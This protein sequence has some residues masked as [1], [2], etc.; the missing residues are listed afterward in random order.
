MTKEDP[1]NTNEGGKNRAKQP[2]RAPR[3]RRNAFSAAEDQNDP[4]DYHR[5]RANLIATALE[6]RRQALLNRGPQ[7]QDT[8]TRRPV[9]SDARERARTHDKARAAAR[10]WAREQM[11][12]D[13]TETLQRVSVQPSGNLD[14]QRSNL[15]FQQLRLYIQQQPHM[16]QQ[17]LQQITVG[18]PMLASLIRDRREEFVR[19][20]TE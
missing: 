1:N 18:I 14:F 4:P 5:I 16:M 10:R 9:R 17:I 19:M 11:H 20:L 12:P 2:S 7:P 15:A 8:P 13:G 3:N 6:D